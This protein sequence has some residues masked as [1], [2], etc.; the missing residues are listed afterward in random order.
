MGENW[1]INIHHFIE[2]S[3][4]NQS[5]RSEGEKVFRK[6]QSKAEISSSFQHFNRYE[7]R[8]GGGVIS[9]NIPKNSTDSTDSKDGAFGEKKYDFV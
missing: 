7:G 4:F 5:G 2:I 9:C 3:K 8:G 6:N 1:K